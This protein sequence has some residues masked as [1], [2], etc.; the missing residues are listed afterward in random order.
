MWKT[1]ELLQTW[2][3]LSKTVSWPFELFCWLL[4]DLCSI[5]LTPP[6][7]SRISSACCNS[8][9]A[10]P[11]LVHAM[12][13]ITTMTNNS[14]RKREKVGKKVWNS[15][16]FLYEMWITIDSLTHSFIHSL[17]YSHI[18]MRQRNERTFLFLSLNVY[19]KILF[20]RFFVLNWSWSQVMT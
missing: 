9:Q 6:F 19:F 3:Y 20:L 2:F 15:I 16:N 4:V 10:R 17:S 12:L 1:L 14:I 5:Y 18:R 11:L 7:Q 13:N 8:Y